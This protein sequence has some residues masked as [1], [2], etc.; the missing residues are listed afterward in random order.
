[1]SPPLLPQLQ[2]LLLL[3]RPLVVFLLFA[4]LC[5]LADFLGFELMGGPHVRR[6]DWGPPLGLLVYRPRCVDGDTRTAVP[7]AP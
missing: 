1:M 3:L 7:P 2:L 6:R 4:S 5:P